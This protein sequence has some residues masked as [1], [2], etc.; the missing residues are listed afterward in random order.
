VQSHVYVLLWSK[1]EVSVCRC[2]EKYA[3]IVFFFC[4]FFFLLLPFYFT[5][6]F[7]FH[8]LFPMVARNA[9]RFS[10]SVTSH[11]L[12]CRYFYGVVSHK[13]SQVLLPFSDLLCD[14]HL[15][16]YHSRFFYV[17]V[18]FAFKELGLDAAHMLKRFK[19]IHLGYSIS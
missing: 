10:G 14:P 8:L 16:Y 11:V 1:S 4:R 7:F 13:A 18:S 9:F 19:H 6:A 15:C 2:T 12:L 3:F 5:S 17:I